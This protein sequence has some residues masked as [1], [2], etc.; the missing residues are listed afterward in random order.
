MSGRVHRGV[1]L[2]LLAIAVASCSKKLDTTSLEITVAHDVEQQLNTSGVTVTCPT[3]VPVAQGGTFT[4]HATDANGTT[5]TISVRQMD[6]DG[7]VK[8]EVTDVTK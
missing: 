5:F 8:W 2:A 4:C 7:N 1:A 3:D 6:E